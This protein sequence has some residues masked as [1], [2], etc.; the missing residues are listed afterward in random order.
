M[1]GLKNQTHALMVMI[2]RVRDVRIGDAARIFRN[3][4]KRRSPADA[5][6]AVSL[7]KRCWQASFPTERGMH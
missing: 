7:R 5:G 2:R 6:P 4:P 3:S 1:S